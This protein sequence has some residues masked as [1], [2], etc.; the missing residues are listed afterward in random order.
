MNA[1]AKVINQEGTLFHG[2]LADIHMSK[3]LY[4]L[5]ILLISVLISALAVVYSTNSYRVTLNQVEQQ[6]QF[7]HYL[8]LQWGQLL[9]EQASLA[10]P[11]RVAD[12]ASDKLQM[13]LPTS[14]NSYW[15]Q[16]QQ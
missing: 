8:Q 2:Q 6:E 13:V 5:I 1:A 16:A 14:K 11:A 9:L 12:L 7:T 15:L 4:M 3:S 10:T